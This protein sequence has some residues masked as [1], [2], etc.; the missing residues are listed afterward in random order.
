MNRSTS[1]GGVAIARATHDNQRNGFTRE[2]TVPVS[3]IRQLIPTEIK[4]D[5]RS[6]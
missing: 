6:L 4:M 2:A 5:W 3:V 1:P